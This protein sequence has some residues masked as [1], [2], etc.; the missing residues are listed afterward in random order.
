ML[1]VVVVWDAVGKPKPVDVVPNKGLLAVCAWVPVLPNKLVLGAV[2]DVLPKSGLF[3]VAL[4]NKLVEPVEENPVEVLDV[5]PV[6]PNKPPVVPTGP[7]VCCVLPP[8]IDP[9]PKPVCGC[10][11][12]YLRFAE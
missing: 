12:G 8:K 11:C 10:C 3:C 7:V 6:E 9:P 2:V 5:S 4:P 1:C